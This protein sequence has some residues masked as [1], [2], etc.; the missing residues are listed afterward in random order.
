[1]TNTD[2]PGFYVATNG[3]DSWSGRL[4]EP[5][6]DGTDG[7][8]ASLERAR[9]A[10]RHSDVDT[11]YVRG[12]T[13][14]LSKTLELDGND[15]GVTFTA[16]KD[17][18]P[19]IS[20]GETVT[21]FK[22]EGGGLYSTKLAKASD[23]DLIIGGQRQHV[24]QSGDWDAANPA[25]S[26]W[27]FLD[28]AKGGASKTAFSFHDGDVSPS[29]KAQPGLKV[30]S[31]DTERLNDAISDVKAIDHGSHAV[32]FDQANQY[33]LRSGGTY[34][35]LNDESLIRDPGEFAWRS[36]DGSLVVKPEHGD[37]FEKD[38]VVVPRLGTLVH[39]TGAKGVTLSGLTFADGRYDEAAVSLTRGEGNAIGGNHFVNVGTAIALD[40]SDKNRIG[41]NVMEH[42]ADTGVNLF[43]A[44]DGN[45]IYSNQIEHVGEIRKGGGAITA[46]GSSDT[47]ADHNDVAWSP[48][49]GISFKEWGDGQL[50]NNNR[51]T[52]NHVTHTGQES[53]DAGGLEI[54]G[55]SGRDTHSLIQGNYVEDTGGLA[56]KH[57]A[58]GWID[59]QKGWGIMLDD[60]ASGVTVRD[61]FVKGATWANIYVHGGS[62]NVVD[63]NV[64]VV[65]RPEDAF[66]RVEW[67]PK[68]GEAGRPNDNTVTHNV[69]VG[70]KPMDDYWTLYTAGKL[71]MGNNVTDSKAYGA[72]DT[73]AANPGFADAAKGDY[74]L[75]P[76]SPAL[77][78]GVHDLDWSNMGADHY[79]PTADLPDFWHHG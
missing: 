17:E 74:H 48:R 67:V 15:N 59:G 69:A 57:G 43:N 71:T 25:K 56:T 49:Y 44:A 22:S 32:S 31:F 65:A 46:V 63:N 40:G 68:A 55:R 41:G 51:I 16:Y 8:F 73:V 29:L 76:Q 4:A 19:V 61:N 42:L 27:S 30:Q 14:H 7:P 24:A 26:G 79:T 62:H 6:A 72:T 5:N 38:G 75:A 52:N 45:R 33:A 20:G 10:M 60:L 47:V 34:R 78:A 58:S 11:T 50:S 36:E 18:K 21:G 53:A 70:E 13:Y 64:G 9:G 77:K 23:L 1:M 2:K 12:G 37:T 66:V 54:L 28:E 3:K 39:M 35:L